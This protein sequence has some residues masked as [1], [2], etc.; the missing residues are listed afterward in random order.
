MASYIDVDLASTLRKS[1][2][3][4]HIEIKGARACEQW[5]QE[6]PY[7]KRHSQR[8]TQSHST[9]LERL[10]HKTKRYEDKQQ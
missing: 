4:S 2:K 1:P 7:F 3:G 6:T 10:Q 9:H 5:K 8:A